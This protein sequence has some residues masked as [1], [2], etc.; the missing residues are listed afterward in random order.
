MNGRNRVGVA[1]ITGGT[2]FIGRALCAKLKARG[3][4]V[5]SLARHADDGPWERMIVADI[6]AG[7]LPDQ[8]MSG[9][10]TVFHLAGKVHAISEV[11]GEETE[12]LDAN[13]EGTRNVLK[14]AIDANVPRFVFISSV[15]AGGECSD[16]CLDEAME[17]RPETPYGRSK[18]EAERLVFRLAREY[19]MHAVVLRLPLVYGPGQKGNL[20]RMLKAVAARRF[21]PLPEFGNNRSMVHVNDAAE[22]AI[23][24][25]ET[26]EANEQTYIV[27]DGRPYSTREIYVLM[28]VALG[29]SRPHLCLPMKSLRTA[30]RFGDM[31]GRIRGL[32][33]IFDS[34]ALEKLSSSAWYSSRKLETE[35]GFR[36]GYD[37][38]KALPE[39]I[40]I[41]GMNKARKQKVVKT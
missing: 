3:A 32:R 25:A 31:V 10:D 40:E 1:L 9:A 13:V 20:V 12:Y 28:R 2:G 17:D 38:E 5:C 24:A 33:F 36:P 35:L 4:Q 7:P 41:L 26:P 23:L 22:A 34:N 6:G 16:V 11:D 29:R 19:E 14:A 37:L 30:A 15:K 21:P 18:L 8:V 27:T 39:I